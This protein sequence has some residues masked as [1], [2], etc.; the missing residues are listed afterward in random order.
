MA[1][2]KVII[3]IV[4][5]AKGLKVVA[6]DTEVLAKNVD[7]VDKAQ[8]KADKSGKN[9]HKTEK[10]IHQANLSSAKGFSKMNQSIGGS[11]GLVGAYA[12]LAANVFAATA[13]FNALRS[14]AQVETLVE[15]FTFLAASAG[16]SADVVA[17]SV[18]RITDNA[19]SMEDAFRASAIAITSGFSTTQ[20]EKLVS[21]G[22]NASIALG[23]NLG[24][25]V[26]RLIRGVAKLEPE[27]LDEL[28]IMVRLDTATTKYAATLGKTAKD[29]TDF[30]RRQA[31]LNEAISQGETK[32]SAL[33]GS[34]SVNSFDKLAGT[35]SNLT[36]NVLSFVN[37]AIKPLLAVFAGSQVAMFGAVAIL[38]KG[39]IGTMF[40]VL[41]DLGT[42]FQSTAEKAS[43][44]AAVIRSAAE[45]QFDEAQTKVGGM[46]AKKGDPSGFVALQK[47]A[48]KGT[49]TV[50][51]MNKS[52][53]GLNKSIALRKKGI[54][55]TEAVDFK[56]KKA[57]FDRIVKMKNATQ[58]LIDKEAKRGKAGAAG[59]RAGSNERGAGIIADGAGAIGG[60]SGVDGI[61]QAFTSTKE[62]NAELR[63]TSVELKKTYGS[64]TRANF[65]KFGT[66]AM[67]GFKMAGGGAKL[68][69]AALV[70]AIPLIGQIIFVVGILITMFK[71]LT[72][73]S[74]KTGEA[75]SDLGT[76]GKGVGD[77]MAVLTKIQDK[78]VEAN[79][80]L[81]REITFL[82]NKT[83][84]LGDD[85]K[86]L[87]LQ[88]KQTVNDTLSL[89]AELRVTSGI[90]GELSS[91][92][93]KLG[94]SLTLANPSGFQAFWAGTTKEFKK[95]KEEGTGFGGVLADITGFLSK[96]PVVSFFLPI[97]DESKKTA[98]KLTIFENGIN[99]TLN[100][101]TDPGMKAKMLA[102]FGEEGLAGMI[103]R[104][105][106][107]G[108]TFDEI[109]KAVNES[110]GTVAETAAKQLDAIDSLA[111]GY[112]E[113]TKKIIAF[114]DR[115]KKKNAFITLGDD[116]GTFNKKLNT[117]ANTQGGDIK[118][119]QD[120]L[121]TVIS[122]EMIEQLAAM[123]ISYNN[124]AGKVVEVKD[125]QG[126]VT[127]ELQGSL[128][129]LQDKLNTW[130][131][132][133]NTKR[134]S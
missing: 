87:Q 10:G 95:G 71:K 125:S 98:A 96:S 113:L 57:Q 104:L 19:L 12:T 36:H 15:G 126:N 52:M 16:R 22:K 123:G 9:Y 30:E 32:Y 61:K 117:L 34:V 120:Q 97:Q 100:A 99:K 74:G 20:L 70:N 50:G 77:K 24:D 106:K 132:S 101:I 3:E 118:A 111:P 7:K 107:E 5:T 88:F 103:I 65:K 29:L 39:V 18:Q 134:N 105:S 63:N 85:A 81:G 133:R 82:Q 124:I 127:F 114:S 41:T 49:A 121:N 27:I 56:V 43:K 66:S 122:P 6:K 38:A 131:R 58:D 46:K 64:G 60:M 109:Q 47:S 14:S 31:F 28:G 35:F 130:L 78:L 102:S 59:I 94:D 26:D 72:S 2:N 53:V 112:E 45:V 86:I 21:V 80:E 48:K 92:T 91:A 79:E 116:I 37:T 89:N 69:G 108:K 128:T 25:S 4:S 23:R 44:A 8:K 55:D 83:Q 62:Y 73:F 84:K 68:F 13:A 76:I 119:I 93:E 110:M 33:E 75:L 17:S 42:R 11:S 115:A 67:T 54:Q 51:E 1:D 129:A 90:M 40:P